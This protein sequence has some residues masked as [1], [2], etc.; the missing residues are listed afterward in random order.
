[1]APFLL[2]VPPSGKK[3]GGR[4]VSAVVS[5]VPFIHVVIKYI[6][7]DIPSELKSE[8]VGNF[9]TRVHQ[10]LSI[11]NQRS[12]APGNDQIKYSEVMAPFRYLYVFLPSSMSHQHL[13]LL[14][15][16]ALLL[17]FG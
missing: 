2:D 11:D 17:T 4:V 13:L 3:I 1:M 8:L 9:M 14:H 12:R 6:H 7:Q 16:P 10:L 15:P 5:C